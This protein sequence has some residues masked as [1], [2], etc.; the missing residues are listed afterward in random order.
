MVA[1]A[2]TPGDRLVLVVLCLDAV[3]LGVVAPVEA[4]L[5]AAADGVQRAGVGTCLLPHHSVP[6]KFMIRRAILTIDFPLL[7]L[8]I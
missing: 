4:G 7:P 1:T 2:M 5:A 6:A 8:W 3:V